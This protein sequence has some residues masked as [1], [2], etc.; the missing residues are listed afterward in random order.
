M[1]KWYTVL[2][3]LPGLELG[4]GEAP[5]FFGCMSTILVCL[6]VLVWRGHSHI[7]PTD[8]FWCLLGP[9]GFMNCLSFLFGERTH[10]EMLLS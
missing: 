9:S 6:L 3:W 1:Q 4:A 8:C 7:T 5:A 10:R 2:K